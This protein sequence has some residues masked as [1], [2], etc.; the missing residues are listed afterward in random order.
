MLFEGS[1]S[2]PLALQKRTWTF[3]PVPR[4]RLAARY[5]LR[6]AL[7]FS[8]C[9]RPGVRAAEREPS[10]LWGRGSFG[11]A[12]VDKGVCP[13]V[14]STL[15][16]TH[17]ECDSVSHSG[18]PSVRA[19]GRMHTCTCTLFILQVSGRPA[20]QTTHRANDH[21]NIHRA[22]RRVDFRNRRLDRC[23]LRS[24]SPQV[25]PGA[26]MQS[27]RGFGAPGLEASRARQLQR[28]RQT[29]RRARS[30]LPLRVPI[31]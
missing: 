2:G 19:C 25:A 8:S 6:S 14:Q 1:V 17:H 29:V 23:S 11:P 30:N 13:A 12:L 22:R 9:L 21:R 18:I 27:C 5:C 3:R 28:N 20:Y 10:I 31:S 4:P 26:R 24:A 15:L 16:S 7:S